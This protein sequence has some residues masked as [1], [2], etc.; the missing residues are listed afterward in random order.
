M[1]WRSSAWLATSEVL[2]VPG[3][4]LAQAD[5]QVEQRRPLQALARLGSAEVL[6]A[7][8]VSGLVADVGLEVA[9]HD[10]QDP[11]DELEDG[12]LDLVGEVERLAGQAAV[13][14]Q[15]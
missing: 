1:R 12:D 4:R 5:L 11:L 15:V 3:H 2:L 13:A 10:V 7:D 8:L 14:G 9:V 6:M